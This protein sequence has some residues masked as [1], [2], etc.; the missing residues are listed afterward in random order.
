[1]RPELYKTLFFLKNGLRFIVA[2][3]PQSRKRLLV[4]VAASSKTLTASTKLQRDN[5]K[6][7]PL[8]DNRLGF[9]LRKRDALNAGDIRAATGR[10]INAALVILSE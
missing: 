10:A 4:G 2:S 9:A 3:T 1:M 6:Q 5:P 7:L 8:P